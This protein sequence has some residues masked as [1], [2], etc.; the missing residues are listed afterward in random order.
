MW[1]YHLSL[2]LASSENGGLNGIFLLNKKK[3]KLFD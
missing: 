2:A 3:K 1:L